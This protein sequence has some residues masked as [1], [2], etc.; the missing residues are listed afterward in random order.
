MPYILNKTN[1]SVVAT[2]ADGSINQTTDLTF[3]GKNYSGYGE[4]INENLLK[5]LENFSNSTKPP[6]SIMGQLWYDSSSKKLNVYDG[7]NYRTFPEITVGTQLPTKLM[8]TGDLFFNT[9]E[10]KLYIRNNDVP[11]KYTLIGPSAG[12]GS[13]DTSGSSIIP[14]TITD[15]S[16]VSYPAYVH[17]LNPVLGDNSPTMIVS[18]SP[19]YNTAL[20]DQFHDKFP[21][22]KPGVNL[23][24][25][26]DGVST[27]TGVLLHYFHG[28]AT[29]S[30][31]L[32]GRPANQYVL[33]STLTDI[34]NPTDGLTVQNDEGMTVGL[35]KIFKFHANSDQQEG[36]ITA[37]AGTKISFNLIYPTVSST[38]A[39]N[40]LNIYGNQILPNTAINVDLGSSNSNERF[41]TTYTKTLNATTVTATTLIGPLTGNVT[42]N[43]T[44]NVTGNLTGNVTGN[45]V[46]VSTG[47][48]TGNLITQVITTGAESTNGTITGQWTLVGTSTL[49]ATYAD[50]A[51]RYAADAVY[52]PGTV[53]MLGGEYEVTIATLRATTAVAGIVS[54]NPAYMMNSAAGTDETHPYI[55]LK[56]R[57]PCKVVGPVRK[58]DLLVASGYKPGYAA[59]KQEN[60]SSLAV[61]GK[62]LEN[63]EGSFGVIEVKV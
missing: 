3:V 34:I 54:T 6:K 56:G 9:S 25:V 12:T 40:I 38:T 59:L 22:I 24:N 18:K 10:K 45:L 44:G 28:T 57:V 35:T 14:T 5:L 8:N 11:L 33:T 31:K 15:T 58:G 27:G 55:A 26:V 2:V 41:S 7:S 13:L 1:G 21:V 42:G 62:A 61:I 36:K 17:T 39:T 53:L 50:L 29:D 43:L 60:D 30:L 19:E 52:E 46:G 23:P 20:S 49:Q 63:F 32:N 4:I 16:A 51:E 48:H 37:I 47:T